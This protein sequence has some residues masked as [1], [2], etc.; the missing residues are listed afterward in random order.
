[1]RDTGR[2]EIF[3]Q[4]EEWMGSLIDDSWYVRPKGVPLHEAAGGVIVRKEG[5]RILVAFIREQDFETLALPKGHV[6]EGESPEE[7]AIRE[8]E[9]ESGLSD[10]QF[11]CSL[12]V[13]ERLNFKKTSWKVTHYYLY[14]TRQVG[15]K[16][17]D[18]KHPH[19]PSW[20]ALADLPD[21]MWPEQKELIENSATKIRQRLEG[22]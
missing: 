17:T 22:M 20:H 21:L 4:Q 16:P 13:K 18:P 10:L 19:P 9:E 7:T 3:K 5:D 12:G 11:V 8:I 15:G 2:D 14:T 6:D 1:M